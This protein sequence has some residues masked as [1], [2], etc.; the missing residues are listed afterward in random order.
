MKFRFL[1]ATAIVS[2][3]V[4]LLIIPA[5]ADEVILKNGDRITVKILTKDDGKVSVERAKL[6]FLMSLRGK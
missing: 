2:S 5:L 6:N 3:M 4:F 1:S